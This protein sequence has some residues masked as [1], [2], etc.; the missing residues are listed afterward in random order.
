MAEIQQPDILGNYLSNYREAQQ[1]GQAQQDR[2]RQIQR[3]DAADAM[4]QQEHDWVGMQ[5]KNEYIARVAQYA[6]TPEKWAQ[7]IPQA[8]QQL[9]WTGEIPDFSHRDRIIA[10]SMSLKDQ[11]DA[12]LAQKK[13]ALDERQTNAQIG[14]ANAQAAKDRAAAA[15]ASNGTPKPP[16]NWQYIT[17]DDGSTSLQPIP[18]GP[19]DPAMKPLTEYQ[20]KSAGFAQRL[21]DADAALSTND[22]SRALRSG[23]QDMWNS[24]PLISNALISTSRQRG[25][26]ARTNLTTAKLREESGATIQPSEFTSA[27]QT[28][29]PTY[30]DQS[31]VLAAKNTARKLAI[32]NMWVA[33][34]P[35]YKANQEEAHQNYLKAKKIQDG[36]AAGGGT[37]APSASA[38]IDA[39]D[40]IVGIKR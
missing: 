23:E 21:M 32:Y 8:A 35:Q 33:A 3:Q 39:A 37:A 20:A 18:G 2:A 27:D 26:Q 6:D 11:I 10:E 29:V 25:N 16:K 28:Y 5:R 12:Q 1:F 24:I 4:A 15:A 17:N 40:R 13:F 14:A 9:G 36:I 22:V 19:A 30:G 34:G 38:H 31:D 7:I